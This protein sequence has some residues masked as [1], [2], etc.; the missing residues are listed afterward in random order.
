MAEARLDL[1]I[2]PQPDETTC[3]PT[4]L[5]AVYQYWSKLT[6]R[7]DPLELEELI[8]EVERLGD[9][10]TLAVFLA[11]HALRRGY[12]ATIYT[13]NLEVFDPTW[14]NREAP[15]PV[16]LQSKLREQLEYKADQRIGIA[17]RGYLEYLAL[18]GKLRFEDLT[19]GLIRRYLKRGVPIITGLSATYLYRTPREIEREF[20][21][22][23]FDDVRGEPSG[24]FVVLAGYN[25][26]ERSVMVADPMRED[27]PFGS[28]KYEVDIDRL[29]C[30]I[31]LG[32]LTHD[33]NLLVLEPAGEKGRRA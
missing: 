25:A 1:K 32:I 6:E 29:L 14:L 16:D 17:T 10:G 23:D 9:G 18:G 4:C 28:H 19:T 26:E 24:H 12:K 11:C 15:E 21:N 8:G 33:A 7:P 2:L 31:L 27:Q 5:H 20:G 3:G 30:S 13:Y 22:I